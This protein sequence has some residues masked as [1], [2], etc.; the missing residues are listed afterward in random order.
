MGGSQ[1]GDDKQRSAAGSHCVT[2]TVQTR[3]PAVRSIPCRLKV[4]NY[5]VTIL[6]LARHSSGYDHQVPLRP[7][8]LTNIP[9]DLPL[10]ELA[11]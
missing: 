8:H 1:P 5:A 6:L 9:P 7:W 4:F 3:P 10:Q 11:W 2:V